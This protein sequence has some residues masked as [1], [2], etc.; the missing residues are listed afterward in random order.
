MEKI[1]IKEL[2]KYS[3]KGVEQQQELSQ[4]LPLSLAHR[5]FPPIASASSG[6]FLFFFL[7]FSFFF[8]LNSLLCFLFFCDITFFIY[9]YYFASDFYLSR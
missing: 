8:F 9:Y 1:E 7:S 2:G 5:T 6:I 3:L 4:M